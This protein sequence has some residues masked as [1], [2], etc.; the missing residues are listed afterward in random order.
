MKC[1]RELR[2]AR[3]SQPMYNKSIFV[4]S[5]PAESLVSCVD[6]LLAPQRCC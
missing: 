4:V 3:F 6:L 1:L 5:L 2:V